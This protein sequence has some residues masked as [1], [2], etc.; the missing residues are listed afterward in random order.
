MPYVPVPKDLTKVKTK[1]VF[2]LTKRQ[3]VCFSLAAAAG[4]PMYFLTRA[5]IGNS[6]A[7][8]LM[9]FIMLPFFLFAMYE[10][11][12]QPAEKILRN[13]LRYRLRPQQRPYKTENLYNTLS[14]KE[15]LDF[16]S[17]NQ[18]AG[19]SGK[20]PAKQYPQFKADQGRR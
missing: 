5:A 3:L 13:F 12:G 1:I 17:K 10:H 4:A 8:L 20:A 18:K 11:D 7:A 9:I 14:K 2:G 16:A 19:R 15:A 6:A